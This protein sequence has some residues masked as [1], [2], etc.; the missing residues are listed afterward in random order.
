MVPTRDET[1]ADERLDDLERWRYQQETGVDDRKSFSLKTVAVIVGIIGGP[2]LVWGESQVERGTTKEK[3]S[4]IERRQDEDRRTTRESI[5][6]VKEHV[7]VI[8]Q[9]TQVILQTI[10]AM[11][12]EQ[13]AE[14]RARDR[15]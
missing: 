3:L 11:E 8:D 15:R 1:M 13:R 5:S 9:N 7:K 10:K 4:T 6:E 2:L 14:R 12:A